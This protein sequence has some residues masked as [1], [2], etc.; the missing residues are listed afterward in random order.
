MQ[1]DRDA[2]QEEYEMEGKGAEAE[3]GSVS[4][5]ASEEPR[6]EEARRVPQIVEPESGVVEAQKGEKEVYRRSGG[7]EYQGAWT[8]IAAGRNQK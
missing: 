1:Q 7:Y 8:S 4:T 5:E 2:G 3:V 6:V